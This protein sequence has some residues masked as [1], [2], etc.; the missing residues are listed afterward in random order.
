MTTQ[1]PVFFDSATNVHRPMDAGATIPVTA[2]PISAQSGNNL[3]A[4]SDGLYAGNRSGL[5]LY[6]D[7][8]NGNDSNAGT[9][10]SPFKTVDHAMQY[11]TSIFPSGYYSGRNCT[12]ALHAGQSHVWSN[13]FNMISGSDLKITFYADPQYGDFNGAAI[14]T[15]ANPWNMSDL[16]RPNIVPVASQGVGGL[17]RLAGIN[18]RGGSLSLMGVLVSLPSQPSNPALSTYSGYSDFVRSTLSSLGEPV[19][20]DGMVNLIGSIVNM[21]D[22][23]AYWGFLGCQARTVIK[24]AQF[25]SQFQI[26][27]KVMSAANAPTTNQLKARQYFIKFM[28]DYAG[29]NQSVVGLDTNSSNSSAGS[30][31]IFCSWSEAQALVVTGTTTNLSSY[32]LSFDPGYGLVNY[33]FNL[34]KT[35]NGQPLNFINSRLM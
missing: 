29:N 9:K 17:V 13:D 32:P 26:G 4:L 19:D 7:S 22:S 30:G 28:Q 21:T 18:M 16:Q 31:I 24:F 6:V 20:D 14:G 12:V 1:N 8:V 5:V 25:C 23:G 34:S 15:G 35:A 11:L 27:G 3:Q 10:A 2:T 33:I